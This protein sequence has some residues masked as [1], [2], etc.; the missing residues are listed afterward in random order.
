MPTGLIYTNRA[1]PARVVCLDVLVKPQAIKAESALGLI[2]GDTVRERVIHL[3]YRS[4]FATSH[5][6]SCISAT[7]AAVYFVSGAIFC[8][9]LLGRWL[10]PTGPL[11]SEP[12]KKGNVENPKALARMAYPCAY[13]HVH[14]HVYTAC[15]QAC[16]A[17]M[18]M[19]RVCSVYAAR[20][21]L[22]AE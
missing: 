21:Q 12:G 16:T 3:T 4:L 8:F 6:L 11:D 20:A 5:L 13:V 2:P 10:S 19:Q 7:L 18:H 15:I 9:G 14:V 1:L 22:A 17:Y